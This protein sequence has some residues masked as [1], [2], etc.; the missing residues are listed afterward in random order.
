MTK[1]LRTQVGLVGIIVYVPAVLIL[2][3]TLGDTTYR[4]RHA[5]ISC[6][7]KQ[8]YT[9]LRVHPIDQ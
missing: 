9:H 8:V 3:Y 7:Q 5:H 4:H 1:V 2:H 6:K